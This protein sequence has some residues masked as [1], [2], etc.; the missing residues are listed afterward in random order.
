[1]IAK[2]REDFLEGQILLIDKPYEWSSFQALNK[3]KWAIRK[4]FDLNKKFKIGHAGTLDPLATGLLVICTGKFT[5]KIPELQG[6]VKEYTGTFTLGATT[7]S[8]DLET[9]IDAAFPTAHITEKLIK[10]TF[11]MFLGQ[12]EQIPPI[13]SALKKDGKRLYELA[14]EGRAVDIKPRTIEI[15]EFEMIRFDLPEIGFRVV[16]S[17][18]T[19]I[20]SLAH[21]VGR[22]L[23]SGAHL[24][25]LRRTKI[26]A[27]NVDKAVAPEA[28][29]DLLAQL[30]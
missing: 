4:K 23:G 19:Y 2:T 25:A 11:S 5:K 7:P 26:G 9:E 27:F 30:G 18:G 22:A 10:D 1:M 6:Q 14:R 12:L 15:S 8:Y 24:S 16:C 28:F 13:F 29:A 21:D 3:V 20:R 17:K